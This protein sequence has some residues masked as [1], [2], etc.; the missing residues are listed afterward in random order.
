[1]PAKASTGSSFIRRAF[2][3]VCGL[4]TYRRVEGVKLRKLEVLLEERW[5]AI[6]ARGNAAKNS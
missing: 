2:Y 3:R 5:V 4:L 1:M 6:L